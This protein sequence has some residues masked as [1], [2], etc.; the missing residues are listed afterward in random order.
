MLNALFACQLSN[1]VMIGSTL[2]HVR[3]SSICLGKQMGDFK[4]YQRG[5][6]ET[7]YGILQLFVS[8]GFCLRQAHHSTSLWSFN[9]SSK[10]EERNRTTSVPERERQTNTLNTLPREGLVKPAAT[11]LS[12]E[13]RA[14]RSLESNSWS[15]MRTESLSKLQSQSIRTMICCYCFGTTQWV[16]NEMLQ[17]QSHT[18]QSWLIVKDGIWRLNYRSHGTCI[19]HIEQ[20]FYQKCNKRGY[21]SLCTE[22]K[23]GCK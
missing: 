16:S 10:T 14:D 6:E 23:M 3:S 12:D 11:L 2:R 22:T 8:A 15:R 4:R 1:V 21:I 17:L 20:I 5:V 9:T 18:F 13:N 7:T 19:D